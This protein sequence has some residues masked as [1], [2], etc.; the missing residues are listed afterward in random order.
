MYVRLLTACLAVA[1]SWCFAAVAHA[2]QPAGSGRAY[3]L[4]PVVGEVIDLQEK[5][6]FGLFPYYSADSFQEARFLQYFSADSA[7]SSI[8]LQTLMRDG[9]TKVRRFTDAELAESRRQIEGRSQELRAYSPR[10]SNAVAGDSIGGTYS[11]ELRS[12]TSFVGVLLS[13]ND[14]ELEFSTPDIGRVAIQKDNIRSMQLLS[15]PQLR[16]GWEPVGNGTRMFFA[17]TARNLRRGEGYVQDIDIILL[18]VNYGITD[19]ISVG[20]LVPAIPGVGLNVFAV[21]PKV[22]VPVSERFHVGGGLLYAFAFGSGGGIAY[23]LGTYGT[24]DN[25]A[26]LGLGY[27]VGSGDVDASPVV[28]VGGATRISRR[29]SLLTETYIADGGLAGLLGARVS[30]ARVSG[31]LGFIYGTGLPAIYPAYLE[32]AYRFGR[33]Q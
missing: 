14:I 19:N 2:Q 21:T 3:V 27:L 12:G 31:S 26:T 17:P 20:A 9:T 4:S 8:V 28:L 13:R 22:S 30:A 23:G 32:V 18:G 7:S 33:W 25:N 16:K 6:R 5:V 15:G 29:F 10:A 11:V 1:A 24:A